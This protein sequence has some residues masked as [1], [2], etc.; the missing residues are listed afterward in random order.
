RP[1][2]KSPLYPRGS[3]LC[4]AGDLLLQIYNILARCRKV[5]SVAKCLAEHRSLS[6][7]NKMVSG[8]SSAKE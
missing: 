1:P 7:F 2:H 6:D 8:D 5:E 3:C 4:G